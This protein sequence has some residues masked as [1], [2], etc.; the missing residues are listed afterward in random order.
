MN[1]VASQIN[2]VQNAY[3]RCI[4]SG[5]LEGWP[6]IHNP[7]VKDFIAGHQIAAEAWYVA[8]PN[9]TV[10]ET[11]RLERVGKAVEEFKHL[12]AGRPDVGRVALPDL[13]ERA[14]QCAHA[15]QRE[16]VPELRPVDDDGREAG[17]TL[18]RGA[19]ELCRG[20]LS[21]PSE[22]ASRAN[23]PARRASRTAMS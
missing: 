6:G 23:W 8:S 14:D 15:G 13:G 12:R 1:D 10:A 3:A 5:N 20:L 9:L 21:A 19:L 11:R 2:H 16:R 17:R 7:S 4:D 18:G 22:P